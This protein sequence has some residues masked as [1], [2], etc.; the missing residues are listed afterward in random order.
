MKDN[1]KYE[2]ETIIRDTDGKFKRLK[3]YARV[4]DNF[5][6]GKEV[7]GGIDWKKTEEYL[8]PIEDEKLI[9]KLKKNFEAG[10]EEVQVGDPEF[11]VAGPAV[12]AE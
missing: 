8:E 3:K 6:E 7:L 4:K 12:L 9:E 5:G 10:V 11:Y 2:I 1:E